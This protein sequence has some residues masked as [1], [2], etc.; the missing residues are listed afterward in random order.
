MI[1]KV[2]LYAY[3][4]VGKSLKQLDI[5]GIDQ[6]NKVYPVEK[7]DICVVVSKIDTD[8]F[9]DEVKKLLS[10]F[11]KTE[12]SNLSRTDE[13]LRAHE[14][15]V[16]ALTKLTVVVPFKFGTI[17]KDEEAASKMLQVY[18]K[19]FEKL[20]AKFTGREEWGIKV[21]ADSKKFKDY[22]GKNELEFKKQQR[23][24]SKVSSKG[25]AY[26]LGRKIEE[27]IEE[28]MIRRLSEI[29]EIIFRQAERLVFEA[30]RSQTLPRKLTGK[31]KEMILNC[32]YLIEKERVG[33]FH[34]Q[35]KTLIE[36]YQPRGVDLEISGPWPPYSF[37]S[38]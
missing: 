31:E 38:D 7:G 22:I 27:K 21:Y 8:K 17:L 23:G 24:L 19:K 9:Q 4:I 12:G 13:I 25:A 2:G 28:E 37:V 30:R 33:S 11:T 14:A 18:E 15:V 3:G 36:K 26:L 1:A 5:L 34:R 6:K 32:A 29:A 20:L 10:E 35:M 16:D